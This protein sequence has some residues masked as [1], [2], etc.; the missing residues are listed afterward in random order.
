MV[1][2]KDPGSSPESDLLASLRTREQDRLSGYSRV[3]PLAPPSDS[4][5][6]KKFLEDFGKNDI[7]DWEGDYA[8]F[9][10]PQDDVH[11]DDF[12][13]SDMFAYD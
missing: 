5:G 7:D 13:D 2:T 3:P 4:W 1:S 9:A 6:T 12:R 8:D 11:P 10:D